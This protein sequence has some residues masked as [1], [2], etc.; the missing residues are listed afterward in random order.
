MDSKQFAVLSVAVLIVLAVSPLKDY[1]QEWHKFS[2]EILQSSGCQS[3]RSGRGE[4]T[5]KYKNWSKTDH[6]SKRQRCQPLYHRFNQRLPARHGQ[7]RR[8]ESHTQ[9][10]AHVVP[11]GVC[12]SM[13][14]A[15]HLEHQACDNESDQRHVRSH[16]RESLADLSGTHKEEF[17]ST[18]A[19]T[20][21]MGWDPGR[22]SIE[23][24]TAETVPEKRRFSPGLRFSP[25]FANKQYDRSVDARIG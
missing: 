9:G 17:F 15:C 12:H 7:Y 8:V 18:G 22:E 21:G 13:L 11:C 5:L 20:P 3:K 10:V 1:N 24:Q 4:K 19:T 16:C 6:S 23:S 25:L 14:F 2:K